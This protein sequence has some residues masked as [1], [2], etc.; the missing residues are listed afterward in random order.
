MIEA[1]APEVLVGI[2]LCAEEETA[3]RGCNAKTLAVAC[4]ELE[5]AYI[6]A[7][8]HCLRLGIRFGHVGHRGPIVAHK[9]SVVAVGIVLDGASAQPFH[10]FQ[11]LGEH[12]FEAQTC[13]VAVLAVVKEGM[14]LHGTVAHHFGDE[15]QGYY[16]L[17]LFH[18]QPSLH[19]GFLLGFVHRVAPFFTCHLRSGVGVA[20]V[21]ADAPESVELH[22]A[23]HHLAPAILDAL[24]HALLVQGDA[25]S[26]AAQLYVVG[27][28]LS[29]HGGK[30]G[31]SP[32]GA[33]LVDAVH[34]K[35]VGHFQLFLGHH[36]ACLSP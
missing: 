4:G 28:F 15:C 22:F 34:V 33:L 19:S 7:F 17:S 2:V 27:C 26:L 13:K 21:V 36:M 12:R 30:G 18:L 11:F 8:A 10:L 35:I 1:C 32:I 6:S 5:P 29:F 3:S 24:H 25:P 20:A 16:A 14:Y 31:C 23:A 9:G